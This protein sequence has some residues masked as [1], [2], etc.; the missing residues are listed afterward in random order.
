MYDENDA[1]NDPLKWWKENGAKYPYVA[2]IARKYLAIPATSAPSE[3]VWSRLARILSL[4]RACLS[5]DL[6]RR[7]MYVKENLLFLQK[8][9]CSLRKCPKPSDQPRDAA[10]RE[11]CSDL[12]EKSL[13][14]FCMLSEEG[15]R[16]W[17]RSL[18]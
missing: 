2:T 16:K 6:V 9:Y 5:D 18:K 14:T 1:F 8:H 13:T 17:W 12:D 4:R 11:E 10:R 7:M 15:K 3:Q